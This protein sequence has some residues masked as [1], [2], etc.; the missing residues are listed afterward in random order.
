MYGRSNLLS[1][2][3]RGQ[4]RVDEKIRKICTIINNRSNERIEQTVVLTLRTTNS[5]SKKKV[6]TVVVDRIEIC[7]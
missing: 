4:V 2:C 6:S 5:L 3:W 1:D 7:S